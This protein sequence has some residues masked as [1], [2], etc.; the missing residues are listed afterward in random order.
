[1]NLWRIHKYY[2]IRFLR[3]QGNP[4]S[5]AA[6][7]AI[8]VFVGLTP[9]IPLHTVLIIALTFATRSSTIAGIIVS[10]IVC[11]PFTTLPIYY[12][13]ALIGNTLTPYTLDLEKV[14][15]VFHQ[16]MQSENIKNSLTIIWELGYESATVL[17]M[18]GLTLALPAGIISY[19][20]AFQ[21]F[22]RLRQ[23]KSRKQ[24]LD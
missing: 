13:A 20:F 12:C 23:K 14:T 18:G 4:R 7:T 6:G 17:I 2:Y 15:T 21:F 10:W 22:L 8:G 5:L 3:L 9:T 24:I 1:M 11:N 19:Y 16:L